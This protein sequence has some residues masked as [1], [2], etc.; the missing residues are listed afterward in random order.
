M[1]FLHISDTS[2]SL[3]SIFGHFSLNKCIIEHGTDD[4]EMK[5]IKRF[6]LLNQDVHKFDGMIH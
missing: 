1:L 4:L 2:H 3:D 6:K 5:S